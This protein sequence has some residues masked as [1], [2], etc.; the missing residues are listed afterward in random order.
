MAKKTK[1]GKENPQSEVTG[2]K[3]AELSENQGEKKKGGVFQWILFVGVIPL[4]FAIMVA[5]IILFVADV[6]VFDSVNKMASK[7][8]FISTLVG[9]EEDKDAK[10][11][12][13]VGEKVVE[14]QASN[15]EY[16]AQ[17]DELTKNVKDKNK[18]IADLNKEITGLKAQLQKRDDKIA[19]N[20]VQFSEIVKSYETMPPKKAAE[21]IE[22]M[23]EEDAIVLLSRL[24]NSTL[25]SVLEKMTPETAAKLSLAITKIN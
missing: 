23:D 21:L 18:M 24:K 15:E 5:L 25:T 12:Q 10:N 7:I 11:L 9:D 20:E 6:N 2:S 16:A 1:E 4:M 8:P 13:E 19:A 22:L 17:I 14:L 3:D